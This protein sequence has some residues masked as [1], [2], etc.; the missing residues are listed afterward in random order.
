MTR[1]AEQL[2]GQRWTWRL[3]KGVP[4]YVVALAR[5]ADL[6]DF[7]LPRLGPRGIGVL[8]GG[9]VAVGLHADAFSAHRR[10]VQIGTAVAVI[11][12]ISGFPCRIL[13]GD[14]NLD[15]DLDKRR[16]LFTDDEH[17]DV[18][19][20]NHVAR[21]MLD[22]GLNRGSTAE[23]N[24]RLDYIFV[25]SDS[26]TVVNAGPVRNQRVDAMDHDPVVADL[27]VGG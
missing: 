18:E 11:D 24:R 22:A 4:P 9:V 15:L 17:R 14:F 21:S 23:P 7:A 19:T 5:G 16:D 12:G 27:R 8:R 26:V 3:S 20:Y 2:Q 6:R 25:S 10:T 1:V 13:A